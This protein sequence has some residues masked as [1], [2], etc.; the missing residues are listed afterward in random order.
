[1]SN[2]KNKMAYDHSTKVQVPS[3]TKHSPKTKAPVINPQNGGNSNQNGG[4]SK[5]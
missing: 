1:M 4:N 2:D 5:K 3:Q